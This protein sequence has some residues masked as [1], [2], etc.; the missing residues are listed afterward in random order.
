MIEH[1][2]NQAGPCLVY[3]ALNLIDHKIYVG[4]TEKGLRNRQ[5]RHIWNAKNGRSGK[6]YNAIRKHGEN[7]FWFTALAECENFWEALEEEREYIKALK[8]EY[9]LTEGGGGVKGYKFSL[10]SRKRMS[11]AKKGKPGHPVSHEVRERIRMSQL[12]RKI[13]DPIKL[14]K[15]RQNIAKAL[16][17]RRVQIKCVSDNKFFESIQSAANFYGLTHRAVSEYCRGRKSR[18]GF[19]FQYIT[20]E[21]SNV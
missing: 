9:N 16:L 10:E 7:N 17:A 20:E 11:D 15:A 1:V 18:R 21:T 13:I 19:V 3:M 4:A 6:F 2:S 12:G 8:P 14:E 5:M